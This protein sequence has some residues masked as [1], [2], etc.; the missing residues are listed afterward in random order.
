[1][2]KKELAQL[3]G[4]S[5]SMVSRHAKKGMPTDTVERAQRW[6]KRHLEPGRIKG[7]RFDP[8]QAAKTTTSKPGPTATAMMPGVSVADVEAAG[9]ELDNALAVGDQAWAAIMIQQ[10]RDSLRQMGL[11][12]DPHDEAEPRLSLRVWV[13]LCAY[14]LM[15]DGVIERATNPTELL[16][17]IQFCRHWRPDQPTYPL[18]NHHTLSHACDWN[19]YS[20]NG[21]PQYPVD[22][23][24]GAMAADA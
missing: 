4:V 5:E 3:L 23:E 19:N 10:V 2:L 12:T 22:G 13:A 6:R 17:P 1:M 16:T 11:E 14:V 9:A 8:A 24:L 18:Q 20:I 7:S 21:W 15:V